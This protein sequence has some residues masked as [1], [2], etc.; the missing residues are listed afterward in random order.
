MKILNQ[1]LFVSFSCS[2]V[3]FLFIWTN[4]LD[5]EIPPNGLNENF[6]LLKVK[7][8]QAVLTDA[9][10]GVCVWGGDTHAKATVTVYAHLLVLMCANVMKRMNL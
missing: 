6:K 9:C 10:L 5:V 2:L 1:V 4:H 3:C 7:P 8:K